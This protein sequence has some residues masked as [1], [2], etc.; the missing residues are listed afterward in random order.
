MIVALPAFWGF[1]PTSKSRFFSEWVESSQ[2]RP[3]LAPTNLLKKSKSGVGSPIPTPPC[4][5]FF[6]PEFR[7]E[8][9]EFGRSLHFQ[10]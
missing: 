2:L 10:Y 4:D 6:F 9:R 7:P 8:E 1:S 5:V 3:P